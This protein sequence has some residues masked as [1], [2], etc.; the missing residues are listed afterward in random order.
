VYLPAHFSENRLPV[1]QSLMRDYPLATL[2]TLGAEGLVANHIPLMFHV[3]DG[4]PGP[5]TAGHAQ[6]A[7]YLRGHVARANPVWRDCDPASDVLAVF[8]GPQAYISPSSYPSKREHGRV[9]PTWNYAVVHAHGR[10]QVRDDP[11]WTRALVEQLTREHESSRPAPWAVSDAP[12][13]YIAQMTLAI[14]GIEIP[15]TR[16]AGKWKTSGN[17]PAANRAGAAQALAASAAETDRR[18]AA[19]IAL[20]DIAPPAA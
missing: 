13:D 7:G 11:A 16:L 20:H 3:A 15:V 18:M 2:I 1:L 5:A 17:Q 12:D 6:V 8:Q 4:A 19:L 10:L 14:V 9:V